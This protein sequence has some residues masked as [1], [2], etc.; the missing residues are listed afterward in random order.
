MQQQFQRLRSGKEVHIRFSV[1]QSLGDRPRGGVA[2][3]K[4]FVD[5]THVRYWELVLHKQDGNPGTVAD[6]WHESASVFTRPTGQG[7]L[8]NGLMGERRD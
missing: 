3:T 6:N 1:P 5:G 8:Q 4:R 2:T 7:N